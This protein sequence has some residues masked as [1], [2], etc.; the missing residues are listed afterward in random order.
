MN[1]DG[2]RALDEV[3]AFLRRAFAARV[4]LGLVSVAA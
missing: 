1:H 2:F 4:R 3:S